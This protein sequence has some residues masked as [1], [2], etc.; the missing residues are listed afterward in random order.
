MSKMDALFST[1]LR[2]Y[3]LQDNLETDLQIIN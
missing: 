3:L 1:M 2:Q